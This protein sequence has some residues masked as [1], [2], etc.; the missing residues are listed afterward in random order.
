MGRYVLPIA[1]SD[2]RQIVAGHTE[3]TGRASVNSIVIIDTASHRVRETDVPEANRCVPVAFVAGHDAVLIRR[4][5]HYGRDQSD[6]V[7]PEKPEYRLLDPGTGLS[8]V[9][10]GEFWP[11]EGQSRP[12]QP[13]DRPN[14]YWAARSDHDETYTEVGRYNAKS[15]IFTPT[16]TIPNV[17]FRSME[18]WVAE[19]EGWLYFVGGGDLLRYPIA[20]N[21]DGR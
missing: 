21:T 5:R 12:L 10:N 9:V 4:S 6:A 16:M 7:G 13:T 3:G 14:E 20:E 15:F 11:L 19:A 8:R 1:T 17:T 2:E 18:M